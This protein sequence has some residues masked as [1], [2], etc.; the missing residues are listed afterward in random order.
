M[1]K[2]MPPG[3]ELDL[4]VA[5]ARG[6]VP[7]E[8]WQPISLGSAGGPALM[9]TLCYHESGACWPVETTSGWGGVGIGGVPPSSTCRD[10]HQSIT[11]ADLPVGSSL[12]FDGPDAWSVW[13]PFERALSAVYGS[14][15]P[16]ALS[17]AFVTA[18]PPPPWTEQNRWRASWRDLS[19]SLG[20]ASRP[21]DPD[22]VRPLSDIPILPK[23]WTPKLVLVLDD[24]VRVERNDVRVLMSKTL[25]ETLPRNQQVIYTHDVPDPKGIVLRALLAEAGVDQHPATLAVLERARTEGLATA[26]TD[27]ARRRAPPT[28]R[29]PS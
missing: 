5:Q 26:Q 7:C 27:V 24:L 11:L 14:S 19:V 22:I 15:E 6:M 4:L 3:P 20:I 13:F 16:H 8:G 18:A 10:H 1:I 29:L 21:P 23:P 12:R 28:S 9:G 17:L 2:D 25:Q